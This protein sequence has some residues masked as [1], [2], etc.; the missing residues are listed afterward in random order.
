MKQE[1]MCPAVV[2]GRKRKD[3]KW[4]PRDKYQSWGLRHFSSDRRSPKVRDPSL[5]GRRTLE[6]GFLPEF[7]LQNWLVVFV[8]MASIVNSASH[9]V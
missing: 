3:R 8:G 7:W 2:D 4:S 1:D 9:E 6:G 5:D